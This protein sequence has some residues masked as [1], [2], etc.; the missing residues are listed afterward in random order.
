[1]TYTLIGAD[2]A[3]YESATPGAYGGHR[4]GRGYGRLDCPA[5]LG[6]IARG[7]YVRHRVFFADEAAA[8]AAGY[9][10]CGRCLPERYAVWRAGRDWSRAPWRSLQA[11]PP[12]DSAHAL[13]YLAA[14]A[15][16][17]VERVHEDGVYRRTLALP[18]GPAVIELR[19]EQDSARLRLP[20]CDVRDRRDAAIRVRRLLGLDQDVRAPRQALAADPH[21]GPLIRDRPGLRVPGTVDGFEL[22]IRAIVHQ[23]VS[24]AAART[25]L[26]RLAEQHGAR[27]SRHTAERLFPTRA[28]LAALD[29]RDLPMPGARARAIVA[30]ARAG[31]DDVEA[32]PGVGPWTA[33]YFAMRAGRDPDA[34]P[35]AD[36]G[37]R[38]ALERLGGPDPDRWRPHRAYAAQHLWASAL[39]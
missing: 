18:H 26:G 12:F 6:A 5:A 30:A 37:I 34:F 25:V 1:M 36:L 11:E 21:L 8:I 2:G 19:L 13:A 4:R 28:A 3:P 33:S 14:R 29:P 27:L 15:I 16:P 7:G 31:T 23:Q 22:L 10:P 20:A 24:L 9:R 17:G 32:I 35:A 39:R 38:R